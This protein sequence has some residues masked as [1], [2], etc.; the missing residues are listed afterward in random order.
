MK[1]L[2]IAAV[3]ILPLSVNA[4]VTVEDS[5]LCYVKSSTA[6]LFMKSRHDT[7][8]LEQLLDIVGHTGHDADTVRAAYATPKISDPVKARV[9]IEKFGHNYFLDCLAGDRS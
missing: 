5:L 7:I 4:E 8:T 1:K 6:Q 3:L 2:I 9:A